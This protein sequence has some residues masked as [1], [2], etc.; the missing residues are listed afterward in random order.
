MPCPTSDRT[1]TGR[2]PNRPRPGDSWVLHGSSIK[3]RWPSAVDCAVFVTPALGGK[4][5]RCGMP[6]W[7]AVSV[8]L[9]GAAKTSVPPGAVL[10]TMSRA[11]PG[12]PYGASFATARAPSGDNTTRLSV[13]GGPYVRTVFP[14]R[15]TEVSE[16]E[17][18]DRR[19]VIDPRK[20]E[21]ENLHAALG[22]QDVVRLQVAVDDALSVRGVE[23]AR[24][25]SASSSA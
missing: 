12:T 19:S 15:S 13:P 21:I 22:E 8:A 7:K 1:R 9:T 25:C 24:I 16:A 4:G 6:L 2:A 17:A 23:R 5:S 3:K 11:V 18:V 14:C 20:S 10:K